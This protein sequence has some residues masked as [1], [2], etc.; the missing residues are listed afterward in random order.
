MKKQRLLAISA[1]AALTLTSV[2]C[3]YG[4]DTSKGEKESSS[5]A[6]KKDDGEKGTT[7]F[8]YET[9]DVEAFNEEVEKLLDLIKGSGN[10]K[11]IQDCIDS[12]IETTNS[13]SDAMG[14]S[15]VAQNLDWYD[16]ELE[17]AYDSD[18]EA[19]Y[20]MINGLGYAFSKGYRSDEYSAIFEPYIYDEELLEYFVQP[21]MSL[22]RVEGYASVDYHVSDEVLD[23]YYDIAYDQDLDDD[24]KNLKCAEVYLEI[25][26]QYEPESFYDGF[27]RDYTPEEIAEL[28]QYVKETLMPIQDVLADNFHDNKY[29]ED[30][31]DDPVLCDE[32]FELIR[33]YSAR[34]SADIEASADKINDEKLYTVGSGSDSYTGSYTVDLPLNNSALVY[35]YSDDTYFDLQTCIHEFGHFHSSFYD[36]TSAYMTMTNTDVAEIQSQGME[37]LFMQFYDD[38]YGDQADA[39]KLMKFYDMAEVI[40]SS[41]LIGEFEYTALTKA[42]D[43]TPEDVIDLY[44]DI[45]GEY[46]EGYPFYYVSHMFEQP[47]YYVSYGVSA[48]AALDMLDDCI[49]APDKALEKYEKISKVPANDINS[50]FR[51]SLSKCGFADVLTK[52]YIDEIA[53]ELEKISNDMS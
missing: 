21:G 7:N 29:S 8:D 28:S 17:E 49:N 10:E 16:S 46:A 12:L 6:D 11:E 23:D 44:E 47:G 2:S 37:L 40:V 15:G 39:M 36:D 45:M 32:P 43:M 3:S 25:L 33:D 41:F 53:A 48:L 38:I 52:D 51:S 1:V 24:E 34:L 50:T 35:V 26:S 9:A 31:F 5:K 42:E 13:A 4:Y 14:Y 22:R 18:C 27:H 30:V 19:L 20:V